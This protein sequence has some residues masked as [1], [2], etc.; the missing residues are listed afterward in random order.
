MKNSFE[1]WST[2]LAIVESENNPNTKLGDSGKAL[3]RWQEHPSFVFDWLTDNDFD[4]IDDSWTWDM[5]CE[6]VL[7]NFYNYAVH[8][9]VDDIVA[10]CGFHMHGNPKRG[11]IS[12]CPDYAKKFQRA[13]DAQELP[14]GNQKSL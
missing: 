7:L 2:A 14:H 3:G 8:Y 11:L 5:I 1:H 4:E 10:A 6:R 12:E 9:K 13:L